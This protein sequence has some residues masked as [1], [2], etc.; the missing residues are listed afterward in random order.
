MT[1]RWS[2]LAASLLAMSVTSP[3]PVL[4]CGCVEDGPLNVEIDA[5]G[6][7]VDVPAERARKSE[8]TFLLEKSQAV[9]IGEV[10]RQDTLT[11]T[12]RIIQSW[13]GDQ[14]G[15]VTL[16]QGVQVRADGSR[17]LTSCDFVFRLGRRY[18]VFA[19]RNPVEAMRPPTSCGPTRPL[20]GA[21]LIIDVLDEIA[22]QQLGS[23]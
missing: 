17:R 22:G 19:D 8:A 18:L 2:L 3:A 20:N 14:I 13:K 16:P 10:V 11:A 4:S 7:L 6:R 5:N 9:F 1:R 15:H 23:R 12:L 21:D